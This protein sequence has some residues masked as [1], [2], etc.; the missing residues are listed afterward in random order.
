MRSPAWDAWVAKA[1]SVRIEAECERRGIKLNGRYRN[2]RC[3][4]CPQCG[5]EDRFSISTKKQVFYCRG[6]KAGGDVIALVQVLDGSD[7]VGAC[8]KLAGAP[9]P[10]PR[11]R[12][13]Q[14]SDG[15]AAP[16]V[17]KV[18]AGEW[19]YHDADGKVALVVERV[20][21]QNADGS[22]V[23]KNGKRD[24]MFRQRRPDRDKPG[25]W[26]WDTEG[27]PPLIYGLPDVIKAI[28]K[29]LVIGVV[30]G[31]AKT[32]LL[33]SWSV[34]ATCCLG[35]AEKWR[36]EHS[37]Q[38]R[39]ADVLLL[40]DND[41]PG[42]RHVQ[43]VGASLNGIAERVRVLVL[44]GLPPKGDILDWAAAGGTRELFDQLAAEAPNWVAVTE[45]PSAEA[46]ASEAS[47]KTA[48]E[49][50]KADERDQQLI[51][52]LARLSRLDYERT[53]K[54]AA[55]DLG[56]RSSALDAEVE[57]RRAEQR[58]R[59]EPP[60]L[61]GHWVVEP[62]PEP[63]DTD[64]LLLSL[65][66]RIQRHVVLSNEAA[67][68][69]AVWVLF[70]WVHETAAVHSPILRVMSAEANSGKTTLLNLVAFLV[71]RALL[72]VEISEATL[73]RGIEL[74][75][76]TIIVD[77]ADVILVNNEPLRA[78][79][80]SGWTRG[81]VVPRCIGDEKVP[82]AFPTF[83]PK[84]LGMKGNKLLDTTL[85]RCIDI[86]LKRK[87]KNETVEH[88]R[89]IDDAGLEELRQQASRW[90]IDNAEAL[91]AAEPAMPAGFDNRLGDNYRLLFAIA[92]LAGGEWPDQV[93]EAAQRLAGAA[94]ITSTGTR[95][96]ADIR[97]IFDAAKVTVISSA[98][99]VAKLTAEPDA[100]WAEWRSGKPLSAT[101]L[102][103]LLK[104]FRIAPDRIWIGP[105][106]TR[107]YERAWF[108]DAWERYL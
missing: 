90:A 93:R 52:E 67:T 42:Y 48:D 64:A 1:R 5:G 32:A 2:G 92:D 39:G 27:V 40:P 78:V 58:A 17:K 99:L 47:E 95:L 51:D 20:E 87:R 72:C 25:K 10:K 38:L 77:E 55:D 30:E 79:V 96:L 15:K 12:P 13:K 4:S 71:P 69:V 9:P 81:A 44:P 56:M 74:W 46:V 29:G 18:V 54:Q 104:S 59:A 94:D 83:C 100:Q 45:P 35:G 31:E 98:D 7:F 75:R 89:A 24:K 108:E 16:G 49:K 106:Q 88:F 61:F 70:T 41:E 86:E 66:R 19:A 97:A 102:A 80:N 26:I 36:P 53:R 60:P 50:A 68:V 37:A 34:P 103:Y 76:P 21:Y 8:E 57:A 63:V 14:K 3:G 73:F 43:A 85:S 23:M 33:W 82:H 62:W 105:H 22:F 84:A 91:K 65:K 6:C 28:G 11:P 101:Q 107:G